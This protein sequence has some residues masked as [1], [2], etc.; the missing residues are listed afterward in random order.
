MDVF[1]DDMLLFMASKKRNA[2]L[3]IYA[4][5]LRGRSAYANGRGVVMVF[6]VLHVLAG[7]GFL[8]SGVSDGMVMVNVMLAFSCMVVGILIY[9]LGQAFFDMAD[10]KL[11]AMERERVIDAQTR[12]AGYSGM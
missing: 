1:G 7:L 10:S 9:S 3:E 6:C 2:G 12:A 4:K 5:E 11:V 8:V